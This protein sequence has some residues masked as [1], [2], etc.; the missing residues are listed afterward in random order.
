MRYLKEFYRFLKHIYSNRELLVSLIKNDFKKQY[1]G[2]YLGLVWAFVQPLTFVVVIWF[3]FEMGFRAAPTADSTPFFLYLITGMIPWFF[4]SNALINGTGAIVSNSFLVKKVSFR[5]SILP[6]IEIGSALIIHLALVGFLIITFLLYGYMPTVYW[7]QLPFYILC[8]IMLLL[9]LSWLTSAI[10]VF[11]KDIGNFI[12]VLTQ[13]G[14]WATPIFWSTEMVPEKYQWILRLNPAFYIVD[15]Y[16]NTFIKGSW[17][18][19]DQSIM[20]YYFGLTIF[21]L[22]FG[23]IV[24]KRLR[25]HFGDVL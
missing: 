21:C 6:L 15:G 20:L 24:F 2:S 7:I 23:A 14:F 25:P 5:V 19:E 4:I 11:V 1:L 8:S 18:W 10:R 13:I 12:T 9:G 17:F 16:R 22:G 3:V